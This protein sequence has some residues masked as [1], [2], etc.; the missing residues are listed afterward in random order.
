MASTSSQRATPGRDLVQIGRPTRDEDPAANGRTR[1]K[2]PV[3]WRGPARLA[4]VEP[5]RAGLDRAGL[6][7][8]EPA[9][10]GQSSAW[11]AWRPSTGPE[12][13]A[14]DQHQPAPKVNPV[15]G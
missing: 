6:G 2:G 1:A 11:P 14:I 8:A 15:A 3:G 5:G 9:A 4:T 7:R 12:R 13:T 10:D